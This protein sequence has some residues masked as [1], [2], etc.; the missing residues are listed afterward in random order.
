MIQITE[1]IIVL[2]LTSMLALTVA[3]YSLNAVL[4]TMHYFLVKNSLK[5]R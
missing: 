3:R 1:A 2:G 5:K 4:Y